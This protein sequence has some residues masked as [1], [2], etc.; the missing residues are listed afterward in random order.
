MKRYLNTAQNCNNH[1]PKTMGRQ[2]KNKAFKTEKLPLNN[3][4]WMAE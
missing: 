2:L 3:G 1:K 4:K